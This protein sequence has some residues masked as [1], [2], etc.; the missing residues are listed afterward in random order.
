MNPTMPA[1]IDVKLMNV[2][3]SLLFCAF[4]VILVAAGTWW[5]LRHPL[6]ALGGI[7]VQGDVTH[8]S[9]ATL[10]ANVA[11]RIAGNFFTVSL[12]NA[13]QAFEGVPWVRRAVVRREF[14]NRLKVL[15]Q[16]HQAVAFWGAEGESKLVNTFGEVFEANIGDVEQD[17]LP[18]LGG[19]DGEAAQV[20]ALYRVL[21][22]M[23]EPLDLSVEDLVLTGRGSW[24]AVL[25]NGAVIELG[26]GTQAE[27]AARTQRFVQTLT[28][29]ASRYGRRPEALESADLRHGDGYAVRL[30]GVS[31][32]GADARK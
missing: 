14:P 6:F 10:R 32:T 21:Q 16:E 8:N 13:R 22:P 20:L 30:R 19:P 28:Q 18:R 17:G 15:L 27:L 26:R 24:Q 5:L 7:S 1:P 31:T 12:D 25:D 23:F 3:A 29:A 9:V 11:P 2:A 4:A